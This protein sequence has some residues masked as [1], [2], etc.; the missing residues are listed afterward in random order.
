VELNGDYYRRPKMAKFELPR[1]DYDRVISRF[2]PLVV[3]TKHRLNRSDYGPHHIL[4]T[5]VITDLAGET[6]TVE[7][8][9]FGDNALVYFVNGVSCYRGIQNSADSY[10]APQLFDLLWSIG[11]ESTHGKHSP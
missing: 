7:F 8:I 10:E 6:T 4:G 5:L 11:E 2:L 9:D 3:M 1:E